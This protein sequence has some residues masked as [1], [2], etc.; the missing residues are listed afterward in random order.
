MVE[1]PPKLIE[2]AAED[3]GEGTADAA[4][5]ALDGAASAAANVGNV[6]NVADV[7]NTISNLAEIEIS[8]EGFLKGLIKCCINKAKA[9]K[10]SASTM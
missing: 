1:A 10:K 5:Q 9:P 2:Q 8:S 4:G 3:V 6:A 7:G